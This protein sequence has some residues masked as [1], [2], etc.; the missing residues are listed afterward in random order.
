MMEPPKVSIDYVFIELGDAEPRT[1]LVLKVSGKGPVMARCVTG[2]GRGIP[3]Q[4][5]GLLPVC[6]GWA[7][8]DVCSRQMVSPPCVCLSRS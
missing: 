5:P 2:E 3:L 6:G 1:V 4:F 7:W 8:A